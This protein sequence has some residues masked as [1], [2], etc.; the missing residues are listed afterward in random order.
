MKYFP[1]ILNFLLSEVTKKKGLLHKHKIK[2]HVRHQ[3]S[4]KQL[5]SSLCAIQCQERQKGASSRSRQKSMSSDKDKI[6]FMLIRT[7]PIWSL[8][9]IDYCDAT[10]SSTLVDQISP[11]IAREESTEKSLLRQI[12]HEARAQRGKKRSH[13]HPLYFHPRF[14]FDCTFRSE[15]ATRCAFK[16]PVSWTVKC[17]QCIKVELCKQDSFRI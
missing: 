5:S 9:A 6:S 2:I 14:L 11:S 10:L 1:F 3:T 4:C 15:S 7:F 8:I 12:V 13:R 17:S 16:K